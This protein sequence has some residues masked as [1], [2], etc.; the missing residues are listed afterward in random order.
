MLPPLHLKGAPTSGRGRGAEGGE[1]GREQAFLP[2]NVPSPN[3]HVTV[4]KLKSPKLSSMN[5]LNSG[6]NSG[7]V[8][9]PHICNV[10]SGTPGPQQI[11]PVLH[12]KKS[13]F[14]RKTLP[15]D[16]TSGQGTGHN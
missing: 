2:Q 14:R 15:Q 7:P 4:K 16:E 5:S 10:F 3:V 9:P 1:A 6:P 8:C 12:H 13:A 11:G